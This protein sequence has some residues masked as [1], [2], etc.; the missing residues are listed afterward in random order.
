MFLICNSLNAQTFT[1]RRFKSFNSSADTIIIDSISIIPGSCSVFNAEGKRLD[2]TY[3]KLNYAK[4]ILFPA[5]KL[6]ELNGTISL[7]YRVF[8]I[9]FSKESFNKDKKLFISPDSLLGKQTLRYSLP[10]Q[11]EKP[12]GETIETSGSI[13]RGISFGNGQDATLNSGLNLQFNGEIDN[14]IRIEGAISDKTIPFQP[15]GNTQRLEEFDRIYLRVYTSNFEIQAGD[16]ELKS[17]GRGFLKYNRNVQG[18][19]FLANSDFVF[20]DNNTQI[21][22]SAAIAKGKFARNIIAG[23]EG[24]QG[25]YRLLGLEGETYIIVIAGSERVYIDGKLITRGETNQYTIDYNTAEVTFTPLLQITGNSRISV[26][27]EYTERSYA[28]FVLSSDFEQKIRNTTIRVS[29]FSEKD[30]K[31]QRVDLDL[32][33]EQVELLRGIGDNVN[34]ALI[35]QIDS[36]EYNPNKILYEKR[37]TSVNGILYKVYH[38]ST[39]PLLSKFQLNFSYVGDG[40]GNYI[41]D[42]NSANGRVFRWVAP[43]NGLLSGSY[44]PVRLMVTPKQKQMATVF[45]ETKSGDDFINSEI[46]LSKNDINTFATIDKG[47]DIGGALRVGF[48][49]GLF[50]SDSTHRFWITGNGALTTTN[51]TYIDRY[52]PVEFE[53]DWNI[54]NQLKGGDEKEISIGIGYRTSKMNLSIESKGL[55]L[56]DNYRGFRNAFSYQLSTSKIKSTIN[57]SNL[58]SIDSVKTSTFNR[59]ILFSSLDIKKV[60]AKVNFELEDNQQQAKS[61]DVL[62]PASYRWIQPEFSL[63][64][65]D[66][67][68][69]TVGLT[70]KYRKDWKTPANALMKYSY[71]QDFGVKAR[72]S[73]KGSSKLNFYGGYRLVNPIDSSLAKVT[74]KENSLLSKIDYS[75]TIAKGFISS[76]VGYELGSGLE[77]KYQFYYI[78]VPAGQGVFAWIDYNANGVKEL[79]EFEVA[80]FNDEAKYIRINLA[81][82]Q[83][84]SVRN[85]ALSIQLDVKPECVINDTSKISNLIKKVSNQLT[86]SSRQKNDFYDL[87]TAMNP[88]QDDVKEKNL[89]SLTKNFRNS[90]A[91]SRFDRSFGFEWIY[92]RSTAKQSL[93]NGYEIMTQEINQALAW[94][95]FTSDY[96]L[97]FGYMRERNLH[98]SEYFIQRNF[99]IQKDIPS[100][101]IRY[102][103]MLGLN[104]EVGY[105]FKYASNTKGEEYNRSHSVSSEVSYS[106]RNKS[107]INLSA[108]LSNIDYNGAL[109]TPIEYEFLKGF[110]PGKNATWEVRIRRKISNFFEMELGYNGRYI[111][112]GRIV[113]T[114]NMQVR[115]VF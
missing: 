56:R 12:F 25:P 3:Y 62:L 44:E 89:V 57:F 106:I 15:Q 49:K 66:S 83:Y 51:F 96:S 108:N 84:L 73:G 72:L 58:K 17:V 26:D 64:L 113:H 11:L 67:L 53:R 85:N 95:G 31:N 42:Y 29:A 93:A 112:T 87:T 77:P 30:S 59:L 41:P 78:E 21:R 110:K 22:T 63:G 38:Y 23:I 54:S 94:L 5:K 68:P 105:E 40:K 33:N 19:S 81:S 45:M 48:M 90:L 43:A 46:A 103:G 52:R 101:K 27:F 32:N 65:S 60:I 88:F 13:T 7:Q 100:L 14:G 91:Y 18:L 47:N 76:N 86:F 70:Y 104:V 2:S 71:S 99:N 111:S 1:N 50:K 107:W 74:K 69:K 92:T 10:N 34:Q 114:G 80:S 115:A 39:N 75:F 20:K 55:A 98:E 97:R 6:K 16:V 8:P 36:V 82:N 61:T 37:D 4:A 102:T 28:R 79:D 35:P 9:S 109:G 24:N